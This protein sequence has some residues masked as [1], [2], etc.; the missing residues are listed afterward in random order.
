MNIERRFTK[1]ED[2]KIECRADEN[3]NKQISGLGVVFYDGTPNTEYN[4]FEDYYERIDSGAFDEVLKSADARGLFN[5]DTNMLLG[6]MSAGTMRL[7]KSKGGINYE[8]DMPDT[9]IGRDVH[10][11]IKRG[12]ITG[13]SFSFIADKIEWSSEKRDSGNVEIRTITSIKSLYDVGPVTFPAYESTT[14]SART[15]EAI[16]NERKELENERNDTDDTDLELAK[17]KKDRDLD[18]INIQLKKV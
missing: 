8:I 9:T 11:S 15:K 17:A 7:D 10:E 16:E 18:L 1:F 5:H 3:E 2:S 4:L 12:D 14:T 13:S 6:R